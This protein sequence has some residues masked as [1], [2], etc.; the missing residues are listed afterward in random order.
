MRALAP[1]DSGG[2]LRA[3][4]PAEVDA[5]ARQADLLV[6]ATPL[7]MAGRFEGHTPW[8]RAA[9]RPGQV[10]YDL[11][12]APERTRLLREAEAAGAVSIGGMPMLRGQAARAFE[13]WTGR[14]FP[15]E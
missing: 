6:N 14:R 9:F 15:G 10:A 2:V 11:V 5:L 7:G 13:L 1:F 4:A 12:Y 3:A 8:P